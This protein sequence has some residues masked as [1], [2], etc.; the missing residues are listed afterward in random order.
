MKKLKFIFFACFLACF[1]LAC[2]DDDDTT[3]P[4]NTASNNGSGGNNGGNNN[5]SNSLVGTWNFQDQL[6]DDGNYYGINQYAPVYD[7]VQ[8]CQVFDYRFMV[9]MGSM[10]FNSDS[11][12]V[13]N[14]QFTESDRTYSI[15]DS[16][17]CTISYGQ[18][19]ANSYTEGG[20][21]RYYT[22]NGNKLVIDYGN[23]T[24]NG[25]VFSNID[26]SNYQ[27]S[28]GILTTDDGLVR[29]KK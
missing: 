19:M 28:N 20:T 22:I 13:E 7:T 24:V 16:V 4:S 29:W 14:F 17:N 10:T 5:G 8:G 15:T 3:T 26:T 6:G 23:D 18:W 27:I 9:T 1:V 25:T 21:Y 2:E 11:T 12:L